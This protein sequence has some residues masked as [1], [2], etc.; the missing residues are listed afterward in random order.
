MY[1]KKELTKGVLTQGFIRSKADLFPQ[2]C[3]KMPRQASALPWHFILSCRRISRFGVLR[4]FEQKI[5]SHRNIQ[6]LQEYFVY[7]KIDEFPMGKKIH[8]KPC[9]SLCEVAQFFRGSKKSPIVKIHHN[10]G[11]PT[12]AI[13]SPIFDYCA[14]KQRAADGWGPQVRAS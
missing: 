3:V 2:Y 11:I 5:F 8:S 6:R 12:G 13:R 9:K 7:F 14:L 4:S 1:I 10:K